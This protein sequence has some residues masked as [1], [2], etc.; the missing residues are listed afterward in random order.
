M[1]HDCYEL[2]TFLKG[3]TGKTYR[4]TY[5]EN[6]LQFVSKSEYFREVRIDLYMTTR[7][8]LPRTTEQKA[9]KQCEI[10][11]SFNA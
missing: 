8:C 3:K 7:T 1:F 10:V 9:I 11:M 5:A 4:P 2:C 6:R